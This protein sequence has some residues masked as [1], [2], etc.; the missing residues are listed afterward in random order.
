MNAAICRLEERPMFCALCASGRARVD[1]ACLTSELTRRC[2]FNQAS[3]D[4][5][6][7]ETHSR[8]S[9]P[10]ICSLA[11]SCGETKLFYWQGDLTAIRGVALVLAFA[12]DQRARPSCPLVF[13]RPDAFQIGF[14]S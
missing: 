10:T 8:R 3:P 12:F 14:F 9:R 2:E 11:L 13:K 6:S 7:C 1:S 5:S 4:E